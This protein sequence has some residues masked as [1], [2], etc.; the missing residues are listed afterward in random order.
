MK[1]HDFSC[2]FVSGAFTMYKKPDNDVMTFMDFDQPIGF[3]AERSREGIQFEQ[4]VS[5]DGTY[6]DET[7]GNTTDI[8]RAVSAGNEPVQD[9]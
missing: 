5:W 3:A 4:A 6:C 1:K 7:G 2:S 9:I 8:D